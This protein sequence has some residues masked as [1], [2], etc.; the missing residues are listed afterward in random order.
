[1][2]LKLQS[3]Q[4]EVRAKENHNLVYDVPENRQQ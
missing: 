1:M 3:W 4:S 2:Q